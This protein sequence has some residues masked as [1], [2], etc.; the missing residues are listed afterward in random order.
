MLLKNRGNRQMT[1]EEWADFCARNGE[2]PD[3]WY[4]EGP[5]K[6]PKPTQPTVAEQK[7]DESIIWIVLGGIFFGVVIY[8]LTHFGGGTGDL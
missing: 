1:K 2:P 3:F 5:A 7:L 4:D 6:A 8:L